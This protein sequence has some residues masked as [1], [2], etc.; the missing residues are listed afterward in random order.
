MNANRIFFI[1][2]LIL[3]AGSSAACV[4]PIL[5][6]HPVQ[7][8]QPDYPSPPVLGLDPTA[9]PWAD[10]L[11]PIA[12][13][14]LGEVRPTPTPPVPEITPIAIQ[15]I[16]EIEPTAA[17]L[18]TEESGIYHIAATTSFAITLYSGEVYKYVLGPCSTDGGYLVD[19][20]PLEGSTDGA[21]IEQQ[22]LPEF[23]GEMWVDVLSLT[24]PEQAAPLPVRIELASTVGWPVAFQ[25][26]FTL[27]PGDW[28][29]FI[30]QES[31]V[32]AGYVIEINPRSAG[33]FGDRVEK[34]L[35]QP[36]FPPSTWWDVL[37][38]QIPATQSPLTAEVIVYQTPSEAQVVTS[39]KLEA[40]PGVWY[41]VA[42]GASEAHA[43][44]I[45][46]VTPLIYTDNQVER[47]TVQPEFDGHTWNDVVRVSI[48]SDRPP[49]ALQV[50]VYRIALGDG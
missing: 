14:P 15:P 2:V 22:I 39:Y 48:P 50:T 27:N 34:A 49:T 6:M 18:P 13:Q 28:T 7:L 33:E 1:V 19:V 31:K 3:L 8:P 10:E 44:Y 4:T 45:V 38:V 12:V 16:L 37:R 43:V 40:E 17:V 5:I 32:A 23:D 46:E 36:E 9:T 26:T 25:Q 29:G 41:G 20:T 21:H 30:I 11:V 24:L 42:L 47:Y 35:V